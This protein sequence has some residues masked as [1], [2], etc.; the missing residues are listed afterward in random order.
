MSGF[1]IF[2]KIIYIKNKS[3]YFGKGFK[4]LMD[5]MLNSKDKLNVSEIKIK[6]KHRRNNKSKMN[7]RILIYL[8]LLY[9]TKLKKIF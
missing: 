8:L 5:I 2:N 7:Y 9:L 1:F 4:I 3:F 6:F